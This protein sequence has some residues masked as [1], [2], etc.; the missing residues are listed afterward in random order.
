MNVLILEDDS[1]VQQIYRNTL[2]KIYLA[3]TGNSEE[4][5]IVKAYKGIDQFKNDENKLKQI[6]IAVLDWF[7]NGGKAEEVLKEIKHI[8]TNIFFITGYS[9]NKQ[10]LICCKNYGVSEVYDKPVLVKELE[11]IFDRFIG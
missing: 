11:S 9:L 6:D 4:T 2:K 8:T 10:L 5:F 7:V 1:C 3:K